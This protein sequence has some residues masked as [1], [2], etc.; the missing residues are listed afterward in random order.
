VLAFEARILGPVGDLRGDLLERFRWVNGHADVWRLFHDAE[1]LPRL[2]AAL[3]DPFRDDGVTKVAG[4]EARGFI[5]GSGVA[6]ELRAG[7]AGVRKP[8]GLFPGNKLSRLTPNDYRGV[9]A[10]LRLQRESIAPRDRVLLV[11]DWFETGSQAL[12]AVAL[13]EAAGGDFVGASVI[14]DQLPPDVSDR[15]GRYSAL[16]PY[17]ALPNSD[18]PPP[19]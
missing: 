15:L 19:N 3:A 16:I 7:F 9:Q 5:L 12:T 14:V 8:G 11:D 18:S 4:I 17:S 1:L 6:L 13:V 2:V 10:E